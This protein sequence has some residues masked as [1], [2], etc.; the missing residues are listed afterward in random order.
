[1][2]LYLKHLNTCKEFQ[3][4]FT[5]LEWKII[6][7]RLRWSQQGSVESKPVLPKWGTTRERP[8]GPYERQRCEGEP[9]LVSPPCQLNSNSC[10]SSPSWWIIPCAPFHPLLDKC[11]SK[12]LGHIL[13]VFCFESENLS[14]LDGHQRRRRWR[15][16]FDKRAPE[17]PWKELIAAEVSWS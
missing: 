17:A 5:S 6:L 14:G 2:G 8:S 3:L 15:Q 10:P 1:M 11:V 16:A 13:Q 9:V 12:M 7:I 4:N